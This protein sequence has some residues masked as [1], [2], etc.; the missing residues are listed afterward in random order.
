MAVVLITVLAV[1]AFAASYKAEFGAQFDSD[2]NADVGEWPDSSTWV[3]TFEEGKA[4]T[5]TIT[6]DAPVAFG[7]NY[8]A[9]NTDFPFTD[10][11]T[12]N[13]TSLK[14]DG[15]T[16]SVGAAY[17]NTEGING[18]LRL[19]LCNKWN[20]DISAQPVDV[21]TLGEF[22]KIEITFVV[23]EPVAG[24]TGSTGSAAKT[25]DATLITLAFAALAL[26]ACAGVLTIRKIK[27]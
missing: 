18:G 24:S 7:G 14:L 22:S 4:A 17:L 8:A 27:A 21:A 25:G 9:V 1:P 13:F 20:S 5:I 26:A 23:G 11:M 19:T 12:A 16:I 3:T 15:K 10:G 2:V 6:F